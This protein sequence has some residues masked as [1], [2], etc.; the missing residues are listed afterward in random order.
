M[1][2]KRPPPRVRLDEANSPERTEESDEPPSRF[3]PPGSRGPPQDD[4]FKWVETSN[5]SSHGSIRPGSET[6]ASHSKQGANG[7]SA[8][9]RGPANAADDSMDLD[10][11][12]RTNN[13]SDKAPP[14]N[15]VS[16]WPTETSSRSAQNSGWPWADSLQPSPAPASRSVAAQRHQER[17][18][19]LPT[20]A[21][22]DRKTGPPEDDDY[23]QPRG[24]SLKS[25]KAPYQQK[26][27]LR[28]DEEDDDL[29]M[30]RLVPRKSPQASPQPAKSRQPPRDA[31]DDDLMM[32]KMVPRYSPQA[33]PESTNS[34]KPPLGAGVWGPDEIQSEEKLAPS[35]ASPTPSDRP[36][37][38]DRGAKAASDED[39]MW[40]AWALNSKQPCIEVWVEDE[41]TMETRW[42][43]GIPLQKI[44]DP[45]GKDKF[46]AAQYIWD[47]DAYE[48]D[49]EPHHV[50]HKHT[51]QKA[52][53]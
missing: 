31:G 33:S 10:D 19:P 2:K 24:S 37:L 22:P 45:S 8:N 32:T 36:M 39:W 44:V 5:R 3:D 9:R 38:G 46:L 34:R 16:H 13:N 12:L 18:E 47:E 20:F 23:Y 52:R 35:K 21:P 11:L 14:K 30:T 29:S 26:K 41:D 7:R 53:D 15:N 40:P 4:E 17:E 43:E 27:G 1:A 50:R 28:A 49:F 25:D 48:Q 51:K 6:H 42:C